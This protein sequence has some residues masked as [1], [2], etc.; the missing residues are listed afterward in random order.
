MHDE[1]KLSV[2]RIQS[3]LIY[4]YTLYL[5]F[6]SLEM[7]DACYLSYQE[8]QSYYNNYKAANPPSGV[9]P[10]FSKCLYGISAYSPDVSRKQFLIVWESISMYGC[11]DR[12]ELNESSICWN[13]E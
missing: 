6:D 4:S 13:I 12:Y 9:I 3:Q 11:H 8:L 5:S 10:A 1:Y 2:S 7:M